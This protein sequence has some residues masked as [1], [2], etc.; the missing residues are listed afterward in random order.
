MQK[1]EAMILK[2]YD[3]DSVGE[4]VAEGVRHNQSGAACDDLVWVYVF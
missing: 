3:S 1:D 4:T 2:I